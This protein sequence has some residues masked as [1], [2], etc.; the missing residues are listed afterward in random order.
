MND[1]SLDGGGRCASSK[2]NALDVMPYNARQRFPPPDILDGLVNLTLN[3]PICHLNNVLPSSAHRRQRR[4][5]PLL[6][7]TSPT[8]HTILTT[9][10]LLLRI[11]SQHISTLVIEHIPV[12]LYSPPYHPPAH[13]V[14]PRSPRCMR[15]RQCCHHYLFLTFADVFG[16]EVQSRNVDVGCGGGVFAAG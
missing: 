12:M 16:Y 4:T 8:I 10:I 9:T 11:T 7:P 5:R 15:T 6:L 13:R 3:L 2:E 14:L 1:V